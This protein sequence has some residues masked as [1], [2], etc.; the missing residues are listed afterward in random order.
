MHEFLLESGATISLSPLAKM[1]E[2]RDHMPTLASVAKA[3][4]GSRKEFLNAVSDN[5]AGL[6]A[7]LEK[8]ANKPA[9]WSDDLSA[10]DFFG[11]LDVVIRINSESL[12]D[13]ALP[14]II[15]S[16]RGV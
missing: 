13:N 3:A 5:I 15:D 4:P 12:T 9:G 10:S 11:A 8:S 7:M 1:G 14:H 2:W 6:M 16:I